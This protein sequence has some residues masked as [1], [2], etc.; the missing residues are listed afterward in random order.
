VQS[1]TLEENTM[2]GIAFPLSAILGGGDAASG[3]KRSNPNEACGFPEAQA[4]RLA[5]FWAA[6]S[7]KPSSKH[8]FSPGDLVM[9]DER[10]KDQFPH[11]FPV[12]GVPA[13]VLRLDPLGDPELPRINVDDKHRIHIYD[14]LVGVNVLD[15]EEGVQ[16]IYM[17]LTDSRFYEPYVAPSSPGA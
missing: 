4:D 15:K 13:L 9:V 11:R 3:E 12:P 14:M 5:A 17:M 7:T 2:Q 8:R 1:R 6:Y 10:M 16:S